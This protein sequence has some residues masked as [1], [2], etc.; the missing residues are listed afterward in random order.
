MPSVPEAFTPPPRVLLGPGPSQVAPSVLRA[1]S[2]PTIGHL[3]PAFLGVLDQVRAMLREVVGTSNELT[4]PMSGT[5]SL[6]METCIV[7]LVEP[8]DRVLVG[9]NGV[10]G[11]RLAEV[12]RRA[13]A[14]V[15]TAECTWGRALDVDSLARAAAGRSFKLLCIVHAETSTGALTPIAPFRELADRLGALLLVDAVTSLGGVP[16]DMDAV[17]ADALYSGTQKCLSCPPGL[18]PVSF[19]P[20]AMQVVA[21]RKLPAQSWYVDLGLIAKYWGGERLY[22]HTAPINMIYALHEA[23][24]LAL[25]EGLSLRYARHRQVSHALGVGLEALGLRLLVPAS[26]RL[27]PLML[28][29]IPAGVDD[30]RVRRHLLE[31]DNV[32]I[33]GGLGPLKGKAW[34]IGLMGE[35]CTANS[36]STVL[37]ALRDALISEGHRAPDD[38]VAAAQAQLR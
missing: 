18:S 29:E 23:L 7:N 32:E 35:S 16:V 22:H 1:L 20:R 36:V 25:N 12:A 2:L 10:F 30:A 17:G 9:I 33:G 24:R 14:E 28:V 5:G 4:M 27:P 3:D 37:A 6:G 34:R 38:P 15:V 31:R 8:G 26:E 13:G 11:Q 19:S 21:Q